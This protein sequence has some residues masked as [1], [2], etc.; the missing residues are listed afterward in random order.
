MMKTKA[1]ITAMK[2]SSEAIKA[3]MINKLTDNNH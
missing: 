2:A 1:K 3:T